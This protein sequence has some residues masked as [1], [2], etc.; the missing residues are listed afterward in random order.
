MRTDLYYLL[1]CSLLL[2]ILHITYRPKEADQLTLTE[3]LR[4]YDTAKPKPKLY[5]VNNSTLV[6]IKFKSVFTHSYFWQHCLMN[7]KYKS[8]KALQP[9]DFE[10]IPDTLKF[11]SCALHCN[12]TFWDDDYAITQYLTMEGHREYWIKSFI[13]YVHSLFD[14]FILWRLQVSNIL[15]FIVSYLLYVHLQV[16]E[17]IYIYLFHDSSCFISF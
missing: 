15:F 1:T 16:T 3:F 4:R 6:G 2:I 9:R 14:T 5:K 11:F 12:S 17:Y 8:L 13:S 10:E 7:I